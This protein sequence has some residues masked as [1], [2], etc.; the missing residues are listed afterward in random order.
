MQT[1]TTYGFFL[2]KFHIIV[3]LLI[4]SSSPLPQ[5]DIIEH[6]VFSVLYC[7]FE[8][9]RCG[10]SIVFFLLMRAGSTS[11]QLIDGIGSILAKRHVTSHHVT[12]KFFF[13]K[14][15]NIVVDIITRETPT[16]LLMVLLL[17]MLELLL[18]LLLNIMMSRIYCVAKLF[19]GCNIYNNN[20]NNNN[21]DKE[22]C[23]LFFFDTGTVLYCT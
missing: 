20:N 1:R 16:V 15:I 17:L 6:V 22:G 11:R 13:Q 7:F 19:I 23:F 2:F 9:F 8:S 12:S 10:Y 21:N 3:Q 14:A 4:P 18:L 5:C